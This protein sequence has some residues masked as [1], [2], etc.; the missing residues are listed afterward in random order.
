M[1]KRGY[2]PSDAPVF[3]APLS[4]GYLAE[5]Q[6]KGRRLLKVTCFDTAGTRNV[7]SRP[8]EGLIA[9]VDLDANR[10]SD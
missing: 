5:R 3:C 4:A 7:W 6:D 8:I 10:V 2:D 1:R 9:V